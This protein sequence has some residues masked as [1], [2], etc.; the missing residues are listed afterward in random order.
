MVSRLATNT[1]STF[2]DPP[3]R[4]SFSFSNKVSS[5]RRLVQLSIW[6]VR[7][8]TALGLGNMSHSKSNAVVN[9]QLLDML[10]A[11]LGRIR[12]RFGTSFL[13]MVVLILTWSIGF[14]SSLDYSQTGKLAKN[15]Q[16]ICRHHYRHPN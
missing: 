6:S 5:R 4:R 13:V 15:H 10:A 8:F 12:R 14:Y 7:V 11:Y 16:A 3:R 9:R 1:S 2:R